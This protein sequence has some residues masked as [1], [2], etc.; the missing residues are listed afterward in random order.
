MLY[1]YSFS[2]KK[3]DLSDVLSQVVKDEPRFIS[4]FRRAA[5]AT[6]RKHEWLEDQLTGRGFGTTAVSGGTL[7]LGSAD[8]AKLRVGTLIAKKD[9]PAL[10][11]VESVSGTTAVVSLGAANG[12]SL[13]AATLT[14]GNFII[15]STPMSEASVNGD[16]EEN[17]AV[18][19]TEYN[20]TQIFRKEIVLSGSALA[21][22]VYGSVDNQ[23][24]RQTAF[25]LSDLARDL[26]RVALFGRRVEATASVRGEAGGLYYFATGSGALTVDAQEKRIDSYLI[27]DAAQMVLA[28]GGDPVQVLCSPGQARVISNEY[29]DRLQILRSDD[30]RSAYVAVIVNE[31]NGRGLTVMADPDVPDTDVWVVDPSGFAMANLKGRAISD[32]DATPRGFDGVRR[33]ALGELTFEFKN[34]KQ[35]VCRI[36][37]VKGAAAAIAEMRVSSESVSGGTV[38]GD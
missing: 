31:I 34:V 38:S 5:D 17:Y 19:G 29:K 3:R 16:G 9:D 10:F 8:A 11:K 27:N 12:S 25:A 28:E 1:S 23:L 6:S 26:N 18:C 15:V 30:R 2:N 14:S 4:N 36:A 24:N 13:T 33:T 7:T 35:R 20:T 21:V 32:G 22:G 37:N